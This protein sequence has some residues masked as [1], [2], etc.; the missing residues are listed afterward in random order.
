[1]KFVAR[2]KNLQKGVDEATAV[3]SDYDEQHAEFYRM[4]D[5]L[6]KEKA[7]A[8][9]SMLTFI[10]KLQFCRCLSCQKQYFTC[11][12]SEI[13]PEETELLWEQ[14]S[15][16]FP[17]LNHLKPIRAVCT[18]CTIQYHP[19]YKQVEH[20]EWVGP[21]LTRVSW[22]EESGEIQLINRK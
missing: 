9:K 4:R 20:Y 15:Q 10:K 17:D 1:M 12:K 22:S 5:L 13:P 11:G 3:L 21:V 2:L 16:L 6:V 7:D 18:P 14:I 19:P 8:R